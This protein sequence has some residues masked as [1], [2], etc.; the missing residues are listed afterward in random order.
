MKPAGKAKV[1]FLITRPVPLEQLKKIRKYAPLG[2][3]LPVPT[4]PDPSALR[5]GR[6]H[7][8]GRRKLVCPVT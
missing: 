6:S 1:T 8:P 3:R 5:T 7:S 2:V 4:R